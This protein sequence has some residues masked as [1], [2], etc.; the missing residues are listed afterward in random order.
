M[1]EEDLKKLNELNKE[2]EELEN[3]LNKDNWLKNFFI[4]FKLKVKVPYLVGYLHSSYDP[5]QQL[6]VKIK[7]IMKEHLKELRKEFEEL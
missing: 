5:P 7:E 1:K 3:F 6:K 4:D 2:I